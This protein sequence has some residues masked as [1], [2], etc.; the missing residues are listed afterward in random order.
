MKDVRI[1]EKVI[2]VD[3]D[4]IQALIKEHLN[5][6]YDL[7]ADELLHN[8]SYK[9]CEE[10]GLPKT[11]EFAKY[12]TQDLI[13]DYEDGV[14]D[15]EHKGLSSYLELLVHIGLIEPGHYLIKVSW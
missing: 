3:Y 7:V 10:I 13:R 9:L 8:Y 5:P 12:M 1:L 6:D 15:Y 4:E 14:I 2:L 11:Y